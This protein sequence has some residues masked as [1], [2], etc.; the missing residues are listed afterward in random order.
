MRRKE[1]NRPDEHQRPIFTHGEIDVERP[2]HS[3][4]DLQVHNR[5]AKKRLAELVRIVVETINSRP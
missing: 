4:A 2:D 1:L 3:T 5:Q